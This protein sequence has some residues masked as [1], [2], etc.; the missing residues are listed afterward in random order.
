MFTATRA[1]DSS[2]EPDGGVHLIDP[3]TV[4]EYANA[5]DIPLPVI[6]VR[7]LTRGMINYVYRLFL[8]RGV[9]QKKPKTAILKYAAASAWRDPSIKLSVER[10]IFETRALKY[11][12]CRGFS[13]P[14]TL[15]Q[16]EGSLCSTVVLPKVYF[17][18]PKN[19]VIIM[20]DMVEDEE[21]WQP[22]S[23]QA[24]DSFQFFCEHFNNSEHKIRTARAIG[25]MLGAFFAQLHGWG[26]RPDNHAH[27]EKLFGAN[28]DVTKLIVELHMR[29]LVKNVKKAGGCELSQEQERLVE[30]IMKELEQSVYQQKETVIVNDIRY[31]IL[32]PDWCIVTVVTQD[33][34]LNK[35]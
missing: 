7:R 24:L 15:L 4:M 28:N 33:S 14:T 32:P 11:I 27:V 16:N 1:V 9:N 30:T 12:P 35:F 29:D 6:D 10:Q 26:R 31:V 20:Q 8:D 23:E 22:E 13:Y 34:W 18:D 21:N 19:N 5:K 25:S 3:T 2:G 17:E